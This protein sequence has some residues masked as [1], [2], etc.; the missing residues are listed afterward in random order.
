L[1]D[2]AWGSI[3]HYLHTVIT[4]EAAPAVLIGA[5]AIALVG[6][7][8]LL[9]HR[10]ASDAVANEREYGSAYGGSD[11]TEQLVS[12]LQKRINALLEYD[13][14]KAA[15]L[16]QDITE[17]RD[18]LRAFGESYREKN[19]LAAEQFTHL[20]NELRGIKLVLKGIIRSSLERY[21]SEIRSSGAQSSEQKNGPTSGAVR[22]ATVSEAKPGAAANMSNRRVVLERAVKRSTNEL[23]FRE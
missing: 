22:V 9:V 14:E 3:R 12:E 7:L 13:K 2:L 23:F 20:S 8:F 18:A 21:T 19:R 4:P 11:R 15:S 5:S 17:I 1:L 10:R 6:I 16:R